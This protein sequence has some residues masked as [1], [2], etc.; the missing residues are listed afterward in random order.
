MNPNQKVR[1]TCN[2]LSFFIFLSIYSTRKTSYYVQE[3]IARIAFMGTVEDAHI[4]DNHKPCL[5]PDDN[6]IP[7]TLSNFLFHW[8]VTG[9][10]S[11]MLFTCKLCAD[12]YSS[13]PERK[14]NHW[15]T[16]KLSSPYILVLLLS[17]CRSL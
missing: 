16:F 6:D 1:E 12:P 7:P 2:P 11:N 15:L 13:I 5:Q 10:G 3:F 14:R 8:Y 4:P 17:C 9:H